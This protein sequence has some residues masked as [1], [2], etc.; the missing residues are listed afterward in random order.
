MLLAL[1]LS[2]ILIALYALGGPAWVLGFVALIPWLRSLDA[3]QTWQRTVLSAY[4]MSVVYTVA[5]FA[6]FGVAIGSY[7]GVGAL[8][9]LLVL[10]VCA[11]IFQPQIIVFAVVRFAVRRRYGPTLAAVAGAAAWVA[12]E[13]WIPKMLGDTY[14]IGLYPSTL[15]RQAADLGGTAGLTLL[16]LWVNEAAA[17]LVSRR[18]AGL[19]AMAGPAAVSALIP[20]LLAGYGWLSL[21]STT[22]PAGQALRVGLIQSN[23]VHYEQLRKEKGAYEAVRQILNTH[24]AMSYDAVER[25]H[26]DAVLWSETAYPTTLGHPKSEIG[27][28]FDR[29]IL[30]TIRAAGVPF[31]FGTYDLDQGGEYN[32]AAFVSP[33]GGLLGFYRK[34]RLFPLTEYV[35]SWADGPW[36][37]KAL[38]WLGTWKPGN[39]A[40]VFPLQL[41]DGR[42]IPVM[43]M[44]CLDD[45]DANLAID[46]VRLGAQAF[47]TMSNDSWFTEHPRGALL[48]E[49]TAAFR[50]IETRLPQYRVTTNGYSGVIDPYGNV[51]AGSRMGEQT[52]IVGAL[53]VRPVAP[54]LMVRWGDW[55]GVACAATLLLL[56]AASALPAWHPHHE[57]MAWA[58]V[59]PMRVSVV[60]RSMRILIGLLRTASRCGLLWMGAAMLLNDALRAN[61]LAQ[62]RM[63]AGLFLAPEGAA[64]C[65]LLAFSAKASIEQGMLVLKQ[66]ARRLALPLQDLDATEPW[67]LPIPSPGL[68]IRLTSGERWPYELALSRPHALARALLQAAGR[69][70]PPP[71]SRVSTYA[72]AQS[73]TP[74]RRLSHPLA[75]FVLLPFL[76]AIPAFHLHEH[77]AYG[78]GLGEYYTFGLKAYVTTFFLW[79]SAWII[80][81]VVSA[82]L[83]RALIEASTIVTVLVRPSSALDVRRLLEQLGLAVLYLGIPTWLTLRILN[84]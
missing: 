62:I 75:K 1:L 49:A 3:T 17:M 79:W 11:P 57:E 44:I 20:L 54:T 46:G 47:L 10:I 55:V 8:T 40:R 4:L 51:V 38:P 22:Q 71:T 78:S 66:G 60:P 80:G 15:M 77:I 52:L 13:R 53:P 36:L 72:Q 59:W 67:K 23:V 43:P 83:L 27:A 74:H 16:L 81:V 48:H 26:V 18:Q 30:S 61:T 31:V 25:Q 37:R 58:V 28:Q 32:A 84:G 6:W 12:T 50:S 65:F 24:F 45:V 64:W 41:A 2:A 33:R 9:G 76:L 19:R 14:G 35:P 63:F 39:G 56:L 5:G 42:E 68:S 82:A 7:T 70:A 34:T 69:E 73:T 29:D 21:P